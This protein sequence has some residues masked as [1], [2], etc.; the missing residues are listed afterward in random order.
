MKIRSRGRPKFTAEDTRLPQEIADS[1]QIHALVGGSA[2]RSGSLGRIGKSMNLLP[3]KFV[4]GV[5]SRVLSTNYLP[6]VELGLALA[7]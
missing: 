5:V 6:K 7:M 2:H 3:E 1:R 4:V